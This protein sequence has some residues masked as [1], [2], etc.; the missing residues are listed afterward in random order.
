MMLILLSESE[1]SWDCNY[2]TMQFHHRYNYI[3]AA[4]SD[5]DE[6][7]QFFA[8]VGQFRTELMMKSWKKVTE[9]F[10]SAQH[11]MTH[12]EVRDDDDDAMGEMAMRRN[13]E[14]SINWIW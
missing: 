9:T 14:V 6:K 12:L 2:I 1:K 10:I 11:V 13:E 5:S 7:N 4:V 3:D 8:V